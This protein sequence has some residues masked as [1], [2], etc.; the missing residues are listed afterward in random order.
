VSNKKTSGNIVTQGNNNNIKSSTDNS[1]KQYNIRFYAP[2]VLTATASLTIGVTIG[3]LTG[4]IKIPKI[5]EL[6]SEISPPKTK[7]NLP[8]KNGDFKSKPQ[9]NIL[10]PKGKSEL[11]RKS[12]ISGSFENL[13]PEKKLWV[14]VF[15]QEEKAY[16]PSIVRD[17]DFKEKTWGVQVTIGDTDIDQ[18]GNT[19]K[20]GTIVLE[21]RES[22]SLREAVRSGNG[23]PELPVS[24]DPSQEI[25]VSRKHLTK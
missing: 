24:I 11:P 14:Y 1:K 23:V 10:A 4:A 25:V 19:W 5:M 9:I 2:L 8:T 18:S 21:E 7:P 12:Y 16:Y 15:A 20:I 6:G 17:I 3:T 22:N 13:T